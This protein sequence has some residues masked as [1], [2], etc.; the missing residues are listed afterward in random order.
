[1][2]G[3]DSQAKE[4]LKYIAKFNSRFKTFQEPSLDN[5]KIFLSPSDLEAY[6]S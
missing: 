1:M 4:A 3:R 2:K 5:V 6:K